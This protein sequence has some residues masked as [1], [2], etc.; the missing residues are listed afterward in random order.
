METLLAFN[1]QS[2]NL[3]YEKTSF[4]TVAY[5][6]RIEKTVDL[7]LLVSLN[8]QQFFFMQPYNSTDTYFH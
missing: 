8:S 6:I 4:Q 3:A 1:A 2:E 7:I 5:L